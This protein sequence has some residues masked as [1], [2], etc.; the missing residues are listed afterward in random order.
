M[1]QAYSGDRLSTVRSTLVPATAKDAQLAP[2][3][4][5]KPSHIADADV[6]KLDSFVGVRSMKWALLDSIRSSDTVNSFRRHL[7]RIL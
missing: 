3:K 1:R 2:L 7:K 6:I 5:V 4:N